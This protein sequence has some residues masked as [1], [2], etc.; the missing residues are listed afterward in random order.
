M[1]P[2]IKKSIKAKKQVKMTNKLGKIREL[3][4][5]DAAETERLPG[6]RGGCPRQRRGRW[7]W[8]AYRM[9]RMTER[10]VMLQVFRTDEKEAKTGGCGYRKR[11]K[12]SKKRRSN[13]NGF[14]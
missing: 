1:F 14:S 11:V 10:R 6:A 9:T 12:R 8:T 2:E 5:Q 13:N 4:L 3:D 7:S